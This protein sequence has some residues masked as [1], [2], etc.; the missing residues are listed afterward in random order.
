MRREFTLNSYED[1]LAQRIRRDLD[2][3]EGSRLDT[4]TSAVQGES[5]SVFSGFIPNTGRIGTTAGLGCQN[6]PRG[7]DSF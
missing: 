1:E 3:L 5:E 4:L 2:G 6:G 7:G